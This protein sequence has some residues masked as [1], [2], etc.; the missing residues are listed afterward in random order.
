MAE[1]KPQSLGD[2]DRSEK[3]KL[4]LVSDSVPLPTTR[5]ELVDQFREI[6]ALGNVQKVIVELAKPILFHRLVPENLIAEGQK[7]VEEDPLD[8]VRAGDVIDFTPRLGISPYEI[9]FDAF[10][11][12]SRDYLP[13]LIVVGNYSTVRKWLKLPHTANLDTIYGVKTVQSSYMP[14]D[15][16]ILAGVSSSDPDRI[17]YSLRIEVDIKE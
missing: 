17:A 9:L 2:A 15:A 8:G 1:E 3:P 5:K 7:P 14:E 11:E 6:L 4:I 10:G 12:L 13:K 16:I